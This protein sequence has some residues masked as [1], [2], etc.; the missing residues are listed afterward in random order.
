MRTHTIVA[1]IVASCTVAVP[2]LA[3]SEPAAVVHREPGPRPQAATEQELEQYAARERTAYKQKKFEGG[4]VSNS[5]LLTIVLV[6]LIVILILAI[7]R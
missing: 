3:V 2:S 6:L 1:C 5:D 4:H 7:V